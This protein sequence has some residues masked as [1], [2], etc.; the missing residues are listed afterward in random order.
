MSLGGCSS[1]ILIII[2]WLW[3]RFQS[4]EK[5]LLNCRLMFLK[6]WTEPK[7]MFI[8]L[9]IV[10]LDLIK[11]RKFSLFDYI[12]T[13][14]L[15]YLIFLDNMKRNNIKIIWRWF[16]F[17]N[18]CPGEGFKVLLSSLTTRDANFSKNYFLSIYL[19][20]SYLGGKTT[21]AC[22]WEWA[23]DWPFPRGVATGGGG[24]G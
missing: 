16:I 2:F 23:F 1:V 19:Q 14:I 17:K 7:Y 11:L 22:G 5:L 21:G 8:Y 20:Q 24:V 4:K 13:Q 18:H 6:D 12:Y 9:L 10:M 3:K 15:L